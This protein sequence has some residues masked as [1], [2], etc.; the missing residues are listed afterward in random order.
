MLKRTLSFAA[1]LILP[2]ATIQNAEA[3]IALCLSNGIPG[4]TQLVSMKSTKQCDGGAL[5][6]L[7]ELQGISCE[8]PK[9][10]AILMDYSSY[11]WVSVGCQVLPSSCTI[12]QPLSRQ[13][14]FSAPINGS[15]K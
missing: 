7:S 10:P 4:Q 12:T 14:T 3:N 8:A 13:S 2:L 6:L 5:A 11:G 1:V 15:C 9:S